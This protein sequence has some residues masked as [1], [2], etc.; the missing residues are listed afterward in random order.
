MVKVENI[1]VIL[2]FRI[3]PYLSDFVLSTY[4]LACNGEAEFLLFCFLLFF[5]VVSGRS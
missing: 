4:V 3:F 1:L 5:C 2:L